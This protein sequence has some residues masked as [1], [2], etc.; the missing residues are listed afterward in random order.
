MY[1]EVYLDV[2]F[3]TNLVMDYCLLRLTCRFLRFQASPLRSLFGAALGALGSCVFLVLPTDN[4]PPVTILLYGFLALGMARVGCNAKTGS[5][6]MRAT[7]ALYLTAFLCGGF[8]AVMSTKRDMSLK[9]FLIFALVTYLIFTCISVGY[10]Y[11]QVRVRNVYPVTLE[12]GGRTI[13]IHGLYDTGNQLEDPLNRKPVSVI[14]RYT[15]EQ[16]LEEELTELLE[17][18][19][20]ISGEKK[21]TKLLALRPHYLPYRGIGG[22]GVLLAVTVENLFIHTPREVIRI[23]EPMVAVSE[24]ELALG[25]KYQMIINSKLIKG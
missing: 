2:V 25:S 4:Y 18:V 15:L 7:V 5:M 12:A 13:S 3:L 6:L 20:G 1:Y 24:E 22:E 14:D 11:L 17:Y 19:Q 10:E 8:W 23:S 21:D 9:T 16:L